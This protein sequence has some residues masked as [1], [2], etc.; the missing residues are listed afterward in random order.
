[1]PRPAFGHF[2]GPMLTRAREAAGLSRSQLAEVVGVKPDVVGLWE[3]RG[4]TPAAHHLPKVAAAVRLDV[5]DLYSPPG[6]TG[7]LSALRLRAGLSQRRLAQLIATPQTTL[8]GWER[9]STPLPAEKTGVLAEVL[10]VSEGDLLN[11][12]QPSEGHDEQTK[13]VIPLGW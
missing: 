5:F 10:G 13:C 7:G 11:I 9:G 3:G 8:S 6:G 1:M 2:D 4:V 12:A